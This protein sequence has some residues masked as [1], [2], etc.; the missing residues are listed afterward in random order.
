MRSVSG[1]AAGGPLQ[2]HAEGVA[3]HVVVA[4][5]PAAAAS[6]RGAATTEVVERLRGAGHAVT[7]VDTTDGRSLE[8]ALRR[9]VEA[10]RPDAVVVVGGD[11]TV[12]AAVNALARSTVPLGIVPAGAGNDIARSLGL[13]HDD[14]AAA[15][16]RIVEALADP[17]AA[18]AP[19]DAVHTSSGRWFAG[20]LST[21]FDST[22]NERANRLRHPRGRARYVIAVLLE[23]ARL[24]P[25]RYRMT[26][27]RDPRQVEAVLLTVGNGASFGGG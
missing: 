7:T 6:R 21:G 26:I 18:A 1:T 20:V 23:L 24:T 25:H 2:W 10:H 5:N 19:V 9:G 14:I 17:A 22:V 16:E 3:A 12:H 8:A 15:L 13:P 27:D 11:G 4:G